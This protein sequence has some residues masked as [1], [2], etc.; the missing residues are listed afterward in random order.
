MG[1]TGSSL[2]D[3]YQV[4]PSEILQLESLEAMSVGADPMARTFLKE[5]HQHDF[6][7]MNQDYFHRWNATSVRN[8]AFVALH[9]EN[10]EIR[11]K[12]LQVIRNYAA[13]KGVSLKF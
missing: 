7:R 10:P 5:D 11:K 4:T 9:S 13:W 3:I 12:Y 2:P 6:S 1:Q 8:L